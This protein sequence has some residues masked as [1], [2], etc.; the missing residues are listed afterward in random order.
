MSSERLIVKSPNGGRP[1]SETGPPLLAAFYL[2]QYHPI[3]ENEEWWGAGFTEWSNVTKARPQF[4][5]HYQP[6]VPSDLG[7]YDLRNPDVRRRQADLAAKAGVGAF[8]YYHYWF[9]GRRLL[10]RPVEEI[11]RSESP[12]FPFFLVWA[13]ENWTRRWN[14][15]TGKILIEQHYSPEDD[16]QHIR[17]LRPALTSSA[18]LRRDGKPMLA[19]YRSSKLPNPRATTDLWRR[20]VEHWGLDGLYL[21]CIESCGDAVSDPRILGFDAAVEFPP[22]WADLPK[23]SAW[24]SSRRGLR[25]LHPRFSHHLL[26]YDDVAQHAMSMPDADYPRWPGVTPGFDN[27]A[28]RRRGAVILVDLTP[29]TY[30]GWLESALLRSDRVAKRFEAGLEG[31]VF[32]NAWNEW[33]E[34]N[35]LEP[36]QR[37]GHEFI[38]A[39][40]MAQSSVTRARDARHE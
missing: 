36:D 40:Q 13:N 33:A 15:G 4:R 22:S 25:W 11:V 17:A 27:T 14:G 23:K 1:L 30:Q 35:H 2:P 26:A 18:Y 38:L 24:S 37:H 28:R 31:L 16:L 34:G 8:A 29:G 12:E 20:E 9:N 7:Y 5:G 39:T 10:E 19:I 32:V 3:P 21:L 6:Q